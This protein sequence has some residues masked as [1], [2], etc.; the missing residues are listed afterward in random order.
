MKIFPSIIILIML[1][2][3][4]KIVTST[5]GKYYMN[6]L[7]NGGNVKERLFYTE[8]PYTIVNNKIFIKIKSPKTQKEYKFILDT[9]GYT[10]ISASLIPEFENY[11]TDFQGATKDINL[12]KT[13]Q[14][15]YCFKAIQIGDITINNINVI[16]TTFP[17]KGFDGIIGSDLMN[18]KIFILNPH[19]KKLIITNNKKG[20][21]KIKFNSYRLKKRWDLKYLIKANYGLN[22]GEFILD[23]GFNGF[24]SLNKDFKKQSKVLAKKNVKIAMVGASSAYTQKTTYFQLQNFNFNN[25][26]ID[27]ANLS[28]FPI[29]KENLLG[30][31]F[32]NQ[33]EVVLDFIKNKIYIE[34]TLKIKTIGPPPILGD[35]SFGLFNKKIVVAQVNTES[36]HLNIEPLDILL[37]INN[38]KI[39]PKGYSKE[40][41]KEKAFLSINHFV[42]ER[43]GKKIE[44]A[45]TKKM[46][47]F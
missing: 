31:H 7:Y 33:G 40:L 38:K 26:H 17:T 18:K 19:S 15:T 9:G 36:K 30:S 12:Q 29:L 39:D 11:L 47:G 37:K 25:V 14:N 4:N 42:L 23:S 8:I 3:C 1:S 2:S 35:V 45:L 13:P 32:L 22:K 34:K 16:A 28:V 6:Q 10:E 24:L 46:L 44:I 21:D 27:T 5:L 41:I 43:D 20:F